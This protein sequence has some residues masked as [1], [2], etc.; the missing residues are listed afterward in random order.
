[1]NPFDFWDGASFK[2]KIRNV[3][4]YRNY[5]KS[6]FSSPSPLS[7]SEAELEEVYEKLHDLNEFTDAANYKSYDE[8]YAR[9]MLV[10]GEA[11]NK[12]YHPELEEIE[13][14][15]PRKTAPAPEIASASD[16]DDDDTMSY[17]AKLAAE[18]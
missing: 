6:E 1:M 12:G 11:N 4:G 13:E 10:L 18:D 9:L 2:L 14:P 8:L 15:A 16:D 5:D 7:E 3:E 17:F